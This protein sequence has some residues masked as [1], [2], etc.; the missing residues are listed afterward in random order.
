M[1]RF[2]RVNVCTCR[3]SLS[4]RVNGSTISVN[5]FAYVSIVDTLYFGQRDRLLHS[6]VSGLSLIRHDDDAFREDVTVD[7]I[8]KR[9]SSE[10]WRQAGK[11]E[12]VDGEAIVMHVSARRRGTAI[13][14]A[15]ET[16]GALR[17]AG[18]RLRHRARLR[19]HVF[20]HTAG[21]RRNVVEDPVHERRWMSAVGVHTHD[22]ERLRAVRRIRPCDRRRDVATVGAEVA[23][24][25]RVRLQRRACDLERY[26]AL[27]A[28]RLGRPRTQEDRRD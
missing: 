17:R 11:I 26:R 16:V 9:G 13:A 23:R 15:V 5:P 21:G 1:P 8:E 14:V 18:E 10:A 27:S 19:G 24:H 25:R 3:H 12:R 20:G 6:Y 22:R 7:P 28:W 2:Y 4:R